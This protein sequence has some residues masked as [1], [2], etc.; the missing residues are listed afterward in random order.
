[1]K[2]Q[3]LQDQLLNAGLSNNTK[4]KQIKTEKRKQ[5]KKQQKNKI[6]AVNETKQQVHDAKKQQQ[7][8]DRL[9]N[10]QRNED[11]EKKQSAGQIVQLIELNKISQDEE[12]LAYN[13]TD[14]NKVKIIYVTEDSRNKI[15]AGQLAIVKCK[16]NYVLVNSKVAEKIK[17][18]DK[19]IIIVQFTEQVTAD[20]NDDYQG[21]EVPDDLMW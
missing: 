12:G 6:T 18:R 17:Q 10:Q 14:Q 3:S 11:A 5:S 16:K 15:I 8:K 2:N 1:M 20:D 21:F 4:A 13:F 19:S 7:N 9:L